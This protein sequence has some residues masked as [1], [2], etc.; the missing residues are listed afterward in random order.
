MIDRE[1]RAIR[2]FICG[3]ILG[4]AFFA[5]MV[6]AIVSTVDEQCL[7]NCEVSSEQ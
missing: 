6:E 4:A 5:L 1:E 2:M 7:V 3:L